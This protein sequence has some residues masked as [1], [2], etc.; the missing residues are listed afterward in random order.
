MQ[1]GQQSL[2]SLLESKLDKF[3][4]EFISSID[5]KFKALRSDIDLELSIHQNEI[6][7]LSRSIESVVSRLEGL[8]KSPIVSQPSPFTGMIH[9]GNPLE[10][11][12]RT[13]IT[14]NVEFMGKRENLLE[15]AK[16]LV[17]KLELE[18]PVTVLAATRLKG[19]FGKPGIV[20]NIFR[21]TAGEGFGIAREKKT[22]GTR[23]IKIDIF[24]I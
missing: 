4:N 5:E 3:K 12:N 2:Q 19:R 15:M 11:P 24:A 17:S 18:E 6:Q 22:S 8:E 20:K 23:Y 9:T 10:D 1:E 14:T 16:D 21:Y 7:S 13:I